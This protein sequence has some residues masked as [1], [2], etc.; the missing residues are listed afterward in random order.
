M[1]QY[2]PAGSVFGGTIGTAEID[3]GAVTEVKQTLAD[4]TTANVSI[5]KHGYVPKAPNLTTQFLRGD[6]AWAAITTPMQLV[7]TTTIAGAAATSIDF[8]GLDIDTDGYYFFIAKIK[9]ANVGTGFLYLYANND[10]TTTNYNSDLMGADNASAELARANRAEIGYM[11]QNTEGFHFGLVNL[12]VN[13][14]PE[15]L[16]FGVTGA[17]ASAKIRQYGWKKTATT[18]NITQLTFTSSNASALAIGTT[19]SLYKISRT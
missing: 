2:S 3:D 6:A 14:V 17:S 10:T 5:T 19:I 16:T 18:A 1:V 15:A 13:D 7:A 9:E 4:N 11:T 12:S 8:S